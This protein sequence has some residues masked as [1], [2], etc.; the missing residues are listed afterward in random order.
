[1]T[2]SAKSAFGPHRSVPWYVRMRG[3]RDDKAM[4]KKRPGRA[5]FGFIVEMHCHLF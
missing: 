5:S 4:R 2:Q 1:M 3:A